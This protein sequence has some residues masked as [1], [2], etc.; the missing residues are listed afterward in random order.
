MIK[1]NQEKRGSNYKVALI[2]DKEL[3]YGL[4]R[5]FQAY[6]DILPFEVM[7]FSTKDDAY[8]WLDET[9]SD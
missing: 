5:M 1:E 6:S 9:N 3:Y 4:T 2:V 7:S 8:R